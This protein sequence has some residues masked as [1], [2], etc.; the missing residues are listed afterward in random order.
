MKLL[1]IQPPIEDFYDTDIRLQPIGLAYL[2]A[3][4]KKNI[5]NIEV[6]ILDFHHSAG[7]YTVPIPKS[8][9]YLKKLY[10]I[11]DKSPF[12]TFHQYFHF[13]SSYENIER[14]IKKEAPDVVGISSMFTPYYMEVLKIA[15]IV[16]RVSVAKVIVG[17]A[18][19]S[20]A[21]L[22]I[23][24]DVNVDYVIRG[25][26]EKPLTTLISH[27]LIDDLNPFRI[28]NLGFKIDGK[29]ILNKCEYNTSLD[30][31]PLPD[32]SDFP[33]NHFTINKRP[34]ICISTSRGCP[35]KCSFCSSELTFGPDFKQRSVNNVLDEIFSRYN[36]GYKHFDFIDD[37]LTHNK[38]YAINLFDNIAQSFS[39][40][41][42]S[43]MNGVSYW[44]LDG[45]ILHSMKKAGLNNLNISLVS[46]APKTLKALRRPFDYERFQEVVTIASKININTV[47]YLILGLPNDTRNNMIDSIVCLAKLPVLIGASIFYKTPATKLNEDY[48][49]NETEYLSS[50]STAIAY[51]DSNFT[52][53]DIYTLFIICRIINFL[54]PLNFFT[55]PKK[56]L[57]TI[58]P[59]DKRSEIGLKI[60]DELIKNKI[61]YSYTNSGLKRNN[62]FNT[63]LF[64]NFWNKIN[65][66][67]ELVGKNK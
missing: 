13:G 52:R 64:F 54:K 48:I 27:L 42:I 50:R 62:N 17:G 16:K 22:S 61:F 20:A 33:I 28:P 44:K 6:K 57:N 40:I 23:L 43:V 14:A 21:P 60:L 51:E 38:E 41:T 3:T 24:N 53:S 30:D 4:I 49:F 67:F 56:Y 58:I 18:H 5:S 11:K 45:E 59:P 8:L 25:E 34:M 36:S 65:S 32:L 31:L 9:S 7:R 29:P 26:G 2:K 10:P 47:A 19:V 46:I 15:E 55:D 66:T 63:D 12:S 1:L 37:N 35:Y 39:D